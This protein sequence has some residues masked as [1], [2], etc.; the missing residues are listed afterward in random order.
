MQ[1][2]REWLNLLN[3]LAISAGIYALW[4]IYVPSMGWTGAV[5]RLAT[6]ALG[7]P[8]IWPALGVWL[9]SAALARRAATRPGPFRSPDATPYYS[10]EGAEPSG[11]DPQ[12]DERPGEAARL[13]TARRDQEIRRLQLGAFLKGK[14]PDISAFVDSLLTVAA[15]TGAGDVHLQPQGDTVGVTLRCRGER[16]EATR[17][18]TGLHAN[19]VRRIKVL[20]AMTSYLTDRPQDGG[21]TARTPVGELRVRVSVV[22]SSQG[23]T[24]ALRL[25]GNADTRELNRLGLADDDLTKLDRLLHEPQGLLLLTGPTGSG[26]TTTLYSALGRL[27]Q[28]R[29]SACRLASIEDPVEVDLPFVQQMQVDRARRIDFPAALRSLLRQDPDVLMVGEIRDPE[30]AKVAVQTGLSGHLILSTL[31]AES[32]AGVFPRLIDLGVEPFLAASSTVAVVSQRLLPK[33]CKAC[34][35]PRS[36]S[37]SQRRQ[38]TALGADAEATFYTAEGCG[39]CGGSGIDGRRAIFELLVMTPELRRLVT[40]KAAIHELTAQTR[41]AGARSLGDVAMAAALEGDISLQQALIVA[42]GS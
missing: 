42:G 9:L 15:E 35:H 7:R 41:Q 36:L 13:Q 30:T 12:A 27:H 21:F 17:Y 37:G 14:N 18:P 5:H 23:E 19:V 8:W 2:A 3:L 25:A 39:Q 1:R 20:A 29:G 31:H 6:E 38:V 34:R 28:S 40:A 10:I 26:K 22:P 4:Q 24:V 32:A 33:L 16:R 11:P